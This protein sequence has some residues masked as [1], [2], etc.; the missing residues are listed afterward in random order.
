MDKLTM[1]SPD[2]RKIKHVL[3]AINWTDGGTCWR[4][5]PARKIGRSY[6]IDESVLTDMQR[7]YWRGLRPR[8]DSDT[9]FSLTRRPLFT[10]HEFKASSTISDTGPIPVK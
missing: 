7:D 9:I 4:L 6:V 5:A 10:Y 2:E 8:T 1:E 3:V